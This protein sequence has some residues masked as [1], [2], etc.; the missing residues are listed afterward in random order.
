MVSSNELRQTIQDGLNDVNFQTQYNFI[1]GSEVKKVL[2][3]PKIRQGYAQTNNNIYGVFSTVSGQY[4]SLQDQ[5]LASINCRLSLFVTNDQIES[6]MNILSQYIT[7]TNGV[8]VSYDNNSYTIVPTFGFVKPNTTQ[9]LQGDDRIAI[10]VPITYTVAKFG[11]LSNDTQIF[12]NGVQVIPIES[13]LVMTKNTKASLYDGSTTI[14]N[15]PYA[16]AQTISMTI[17]NTDSSVSTAIKTEIAQFNSTTEAQY[18]IR[19]KD[20][21]IDVTNTM[22]LYMGKIEN[23]AGSVSLLKLVFEQTDTSNISNGD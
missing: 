9:I 3:L 7:A 21:S 13:A 11:I 8:V 20:N 18:T 4:D 1:I 15:K 2:K 10:E 16:K 6:V 23:T 5:D 14:V 19:Y 12:I 17:L 22:D